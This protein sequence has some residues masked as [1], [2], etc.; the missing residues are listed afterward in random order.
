MA[1][2]VILPKLTYEMLEG[3][4]LEWLCAEGDAVAAGQALFT[5]ETDKAAVEV[6]AD[7]TET[8]LLK[9]LSEEPAHV[10]DVG[11]AA[12]LPIATVSSTLALMEL[13]GLVRQVGGM[14]YV[15][16]RE[17]GPVYQVD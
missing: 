11:R 14:N 15:R 7:E 1:S 10:D 13:K 6:P 9:Q 2:Q 4:I 5:V 3:R 16:A 12:G 8:L 17:S